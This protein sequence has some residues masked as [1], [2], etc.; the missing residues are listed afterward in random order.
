MHKALCVSRQ[1]EQ[2]CLD[3]HILSTGQS[4]VR[5]CKQSFHFASPRAR[6]STL[7]PPPSFGHGVLYIRGLFENVNPSGFGGR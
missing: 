4:A 3:L 6:L 7:T 5:R 2:K 1:E